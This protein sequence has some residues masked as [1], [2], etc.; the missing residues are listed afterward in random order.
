ML[1]EQLGQLE[2]GG[3]ILRGRGDLT[4]LGARGVGWPWDPFG[5]AWQGLPDGKTA[6]SE[7]FLQ[8]CKESA[9]STVENGEGLDSIQINRVVVWL[10]GWASDGGCDQ[11]GGRLHRHSAV[12]CGAV[13]CS[14][15]P[16]GRGEGEARSE[17]DGRC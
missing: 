1:K 7:I 12:R 6:R 8:W 3:A 15:W 14:Q 9:S 4:G 2:G 5:L 10:C 13:R 16:R 11:V 17:T